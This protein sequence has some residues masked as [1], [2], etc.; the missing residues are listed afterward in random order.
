MTIDKI[1]EKMSEEVKCFSHFSY[2]SK[3]QRHFYTWYHIYMNGFLL[4][5]LD[6]YLRDNALHE[7][8]SYKKVSNPPLG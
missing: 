3:Q 5:P 1:L 8:R 4:N 7:L 2:M 6:H